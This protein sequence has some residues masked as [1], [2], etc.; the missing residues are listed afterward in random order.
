KRAGLRALSS[1]IGKMGF[2]IKGRF[3]IRDL[4]LT[5]FELITIG[6]NTFL[7]HRCLLLCDVIERNSVSSCWARCCCLSK[8]TGE[9]FLCFICLLVGIAG[10]L[11]IPPA[12][13][14]FSP[15]WF[16]PLDRK[17][18]PLLHCRVLREPEEQR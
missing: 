13:P 1:L 7:G 4:R 8:E 14:S 6:L 9:H 17:L 11:F 15:Q 10:V 12:I 5:A 2:P 18:A 3:F 16:W